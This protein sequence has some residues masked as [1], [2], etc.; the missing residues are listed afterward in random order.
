MCLRKRKEIRAGGGERREE[1]RRDRWEVKVV[2]SWV[3]KG[4]RFLF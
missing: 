2:F 3:F 1:R 4:F